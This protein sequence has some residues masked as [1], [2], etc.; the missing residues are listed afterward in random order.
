MDIEIRRLTQGKK[1][2]DDLM[3]Y[4]YQHYYQ[5]AHRGFT[6]EEFWQACS[7][8]ARSPLDEIRRYVDTTAEIDYPKYLGYAGL[9]MDTDYRI[10]FQQNQDKAPVQLFKQTD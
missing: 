9:E 8:V 10:H 3:R 4:L 6:E 2:L 5:A 1:N 7:L